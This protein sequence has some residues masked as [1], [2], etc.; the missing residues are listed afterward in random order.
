MSIHPSLA[1]RLRLYDELQEYIKK[2]QGVVF[3]DL[4]TLCN[5]DLTFLDC[6]DAPMEV[7]LFDTR[8]GKER[9]VK[10]T[11]VSTETIAEIVSLIR[12]KTIVNNLQN[13]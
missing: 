2:E 8:S 4:V 1:V 7:Y 10:I 6:E 9:E 5:N 12:K 11:E 3:H 13:L